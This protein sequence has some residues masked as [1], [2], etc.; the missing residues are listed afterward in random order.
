M[1]AKVKEYLDLVTKVS[2]EKGCTKARSMAGLLS[3]KRW[4]ENKF[5]KSFDD[6]DPD[7]MYGDVFDAFLN[8]KSKTRR[9]D[10]TIQQQQQLDPYRP[11]FPTV[12]FE[13]KAKPIA[14]SQQFVSISARCLPRSAT[15]LMTLSILSTSSM[16]AYYPAWRSL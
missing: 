8:K 15:Y 4:Y 6:T 12:C 2:C 11:T 3:T 5:G 7:E 1:L 16:S 10:G 14:Q 9:T 13:I